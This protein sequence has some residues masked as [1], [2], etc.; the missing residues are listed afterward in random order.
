MGN[1][2]TNHVQGFAVVDSRWKAANL[3]TNDAASGNSDY[4]EASPQPGQMELEADGNQGRLEIS[5]GQSTTFYGK[6]ALGG[7]AAFNSSGIAYRIEGETSDKDWRGWNPPSF[8]QYWSYLRNGSTDNYGLCV[9]RQTQKVWAVIG[10]SGTLTVYQADATDGS[11]SSAVSSPLSDSFG[12]WG[13][14]EHKGTLYFVTSGNAT[15]GIQTLTASESDFVFSLAFQQPKGVTFGG[16]TDRADLAIDDRGQMLFVVRR[17][18]NNLYQFASQNFGATWSYIGTLAGQNTLGQVVAIPG[19]GF[20]VSSVGILAGV[21]ILPDAFTPLDDVDTLSPHGAYVPTDGAF[22]AWADLD[23]AYYSLSDTSSG[24]IELRVSI[25]GGATWQLTECGLGNFGSTADKLTNFRVLPYAGGAL[26]HHATKADVNT[27]IQHT[28]VWQLGGWAKVESEA[29]LSSTEDF[30]PANRLAFGVSAFTSGHTWLPFE[31]PDNM[32]GV[33]TQVGATAGVI[34]TTGEMDINTSASSG[35]YQNTLAAGAATIT[36]GQFRVQSGGSLTTADAGFGS[37]WAD[38]VADY[39]VRIYANTTQFVV[40]DVHGATALATIT[41]AHDFRFGFT[42]ILMYHDQADVQV[43]YRA[44]G[45]STEWIHAVTSSAVTNAGASAATSLVYFGNLATST[46][47]SYWRGFYAVS[48]TNDLQPFRSGLSPTLGNRIRGRWLTVEPIPVPNVGTSTDHAFASMVRGPALRDEVMTIEPSHRYP[49]ESVFPLDSAS[50]SDEWRSTSD[51][52]D[53]R[54]SVDF[55]RDTALDGS[56]AL[57]LGL[58]NTNLTAC[59]LEGW[60]GSAW[61]TLG[62]YNGATGFSGLTYQLTGDVIRP[63]AATADAG[64][65]LQAGEMVGGYAILDPAGTPK[66]RKIAYHTGGSWSGDTTA[67][68]FIRLEGIDGT[69]L[70]T[71]TVKLVAPSGCL[72]VYLSGAASTHYERFSLLI[73]ASANETAEGYFKIGAAPLGAVTAVG[74]RWGRGWSR[75]HE[76]NVSSYG[77]EYGTIRRRQDGPNARRWSMSWQTGLNVRQ[78]RQGLD[79]N[80]VSPNG[81]AQPLAADQDVWWQLVSVFEQAKG[82]EIPV[83]ACARLPTSSGTTLTDPTAWLYGTL[84]GTVQAN[85][86]VGDE[87][88]GEAMRVESI[89]VEEQL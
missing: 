32:A 7:D 37:R 69:E 19:G 80:Y 89:T 61:T 64:R 12:Q 86:V 17:G 3:R 66:V 79:N 28:A 70:A 49:V 20:M 9:N 52:S 84:S 6:A 45:F 83:I 53:V 72:F 8:P 62:T 40:Y 25:D 74:Q 77:T 34:T 43:W 46:T 33:Y 42:Q 14:A 23:G 35:S 27:T 73:E 13:I 59:K 39:R 41:P 60:D 36:C 54:L 44:P 56:W 15:S 65:F 87:L 4:T 22:A 68:P 26:L 16:T 29:I 75:A 47:R 1:R 31:L 82:G 88:D 11:W 50:P 76:P 18:D 10:V 81:T 51:A 24:G 2:I 21:R 63:D 30:D 38:G 78:L 57:A 67:R 48:D 5:G 58:V 55:T 85:N 71:G